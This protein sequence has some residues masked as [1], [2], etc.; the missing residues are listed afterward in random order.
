MKNLKV[1]SDKMEKIKLLEK[2]LNDNG[3]LIVSEIG[4]SFKFVDDVID[5][6]YY[7]VI[8]A[9]DTHQDF[10]NLPDHFPYEFEFKVAFSRG[11]RRFEDI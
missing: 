1:E 10:T 4:I 6:A 8:D 3:M 7:T 9:E 11:N 2:F 5:D